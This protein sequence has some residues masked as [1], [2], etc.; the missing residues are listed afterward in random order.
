[1]SMHAGHATFAGAVCIEA[2][3]PIKPSP[4]TMGPKQ[5]EDCQPCSLTEINLNRLG[6]VMHTS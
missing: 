5:V 4:L 6:D 1:M 3:D 2:P